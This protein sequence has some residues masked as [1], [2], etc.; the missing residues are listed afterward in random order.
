MFKHLNRLLGV[1]MHFAV[2]FVWFLI[3]T[4]K[5]CGWGNQTTCILR[6]LYRYFW[7][8]YAL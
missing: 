8:V 3:K 5:H 6:S 4:L 1:K 2:I 7:I